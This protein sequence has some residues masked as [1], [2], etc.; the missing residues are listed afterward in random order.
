MKTRCINLKY[1]EVRGLLDGSILAIWRP[2]KPQ[3]WKDPFD[4]LLLTTA[5]HTVTMADVWKI[6]PY[7]KSG[8]RLMAGISG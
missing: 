5:K 4:S 1:H 7:G 6:C 8:D 3:P 2:M